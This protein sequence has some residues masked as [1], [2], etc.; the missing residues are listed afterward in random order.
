MDPFAT[1][2]GPGC[3][4]LLN[5]GKKRL[6]LYQDRH[7]VGMEMRVPKS[8]AP[9]IHLIFLLCYR[10]EDIYIYIYIFPSI[11][12]CRENALNLKK[13]IKWFLILSLYRLGNDWM[14]LS[15]H[16]K[17]PQTGCLE[18][19]EIYF[20]YFWTLEVQDQGTNIFGVWWGPASWFI[21][22][23]LLTVLSHGQRGAELCGVF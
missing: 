18:T 22:D 20:F 2:V 4:L 14:C 19:T 21:D 17:I 11:L 6:T 10:R 3:T 8:L 12:F 1:V 9:I 15:C 23:Y 7:R 13:I 5:A 16:N